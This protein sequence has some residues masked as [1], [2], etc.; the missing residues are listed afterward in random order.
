MNKGNIYIIEDEEITLL[1]ISYFLKLRGFEILGTSP[2]GEKAIPEIK[3]LKPDLIL[4]DINLEG[5]LDGIETASIIY[6][7]LICPI[8]YI[9]SDIE[10]ET[11]NRLMT[12]RPYGYLKKP[13][14]FDALSNTLELAIE[15]FRTENQLKES[16]ALFSLLINGL[17]DYSIILLKPDGKILDWNNSAELLFGFTPTQMVNKHFSVL[18]PNTNPH[19][20]QPENLLLSSIQNESYDAEGFL[21][22]ESGNNVYANYVITPLRE[23]SGD[24]KGFSLIVRDISERK[25]IDEERILIQNKLKKYNEDLE[26]KVAERT[27]ELRELN[28]KLLKEIKIN[29]L[30]EKQIIKSH[31][32]L[33][34][35]QELAHFG[36]WELNYESLDT[37]L[38]PETCK[39]LDIDL[40]YNIKISEFLN[41]IHSDDP[42]L[43]FDSAFKEKDE[44]QYDKLILSSKG[45]ETYVNIIAR[46]VR[47]SK[48]IEKIFGTIHDIT[49]RKRAEN[50]LNLA[51]EKE[52]EVNK[53]KNRFVSMISHEFRTPLTVILSTIQLLEKFSERYD[54]EEKKNK[55]QK[56]YNGFNKL[57]ELLEDILQLGRIQEKRTLLNQE[58]IPLFHFLNSIIDELSH[59]EHGNNRIV[60]KYEIEEKFIYFSD[61]KLLRHIVINLLI[62]SL[63]YSPKEKSVFLRVFLGENNRIYFEIHDEGIGIPKDEQPYIFDTFFR[64]SNAT[65]KHGTGLGLALTK[66]YIN[67]LQGEI[68]LDS[69]EGKYSIFTV[70]LPYHK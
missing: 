59:T 24:L 17:R 70:S 28:D 45:R 37:I 65:V 35:A 44:L 67:Y 63:K 23:I 11:I 57:N 39:I 5:E 51:L 58:D 46:V 3:E 21:I 9:T 18:F 56:I 40:N 53:M 22:S 1:Q 69:E 30:F 36:D 50:E 10:P 43:N 13:L 68:F 32:N 15:K 29:K 41:I 38:S 33:L 52:K 26:R 49:L 42:N 55:Y 66:E 14:R 25:K 8:V 19:S 60:L 6:K 20:Q 54:E 64:S 48:G 62:N 31:K 12:T 4:I 47:N 2:S 61:P 7:D 34:E 27:S 16:E